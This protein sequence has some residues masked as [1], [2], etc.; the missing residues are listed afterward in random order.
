[1]MGYDH[2]DEHGTILWMRL[3]SISAAFWS[4]NSLYNN[5]KETVVG[6]H[7]WTQLGVSSNRRYL[8]LC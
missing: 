3:S 6:M 5:T 2:T 4:G 7:R 1:M 8:K